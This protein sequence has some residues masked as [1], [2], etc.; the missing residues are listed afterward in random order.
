MNI[1]HYLPVLEQTYNCRNKLEKE[2]LSYFESI[3]RK[4]V[5]KKQLPELKQKILSKI[6]QLNEANHRCFP[7]K[8]YFETDDCFPGNEAKDIVVRDARC[9]HFILRACTLSH[10]SS[11]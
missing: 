8:I 1:T 5:E 7:I 3:D 10:I 4:M 9:L 6:N 2:V 11:L